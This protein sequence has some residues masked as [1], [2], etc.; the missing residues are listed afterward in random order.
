MYRDLSSAVCRRKITQQAATVPLCMIA[1]RSVMPALPEAMSANHA[2]APRQP[3]L[4]EEIA[5]ME[6]QAIVTGALQ[7]EVERH[8]MKHSID[9]SPKGQQ[10]LSPTDAGVSNT[11][12]RA[13]VRVNASSPVKTYPDGSTWTI[14]DG[15][16]SEEENAPEDDEPL[17][18]DQSRRSHVAGAC[19]SSGDAEGPVD[20]REKCIK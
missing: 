19:A 11:P 4:A 6:E 1:E 8:G 5:E 2:G 17:S 16:S 14:E 3:S 7:A 12:R 10:P 13:Q 18:E 20:A 15:A 9:K